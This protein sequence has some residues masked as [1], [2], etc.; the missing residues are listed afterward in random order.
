VLGDGGTVFGRQNT[1][2]YLAFTMGRNNQALGG[3]VFGQSN[4]TQ[5]GSSLLVAG[6]SNQVF[7]DYG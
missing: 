5:F 3:Y 4:K 7:D 1:A 2:G 6:T